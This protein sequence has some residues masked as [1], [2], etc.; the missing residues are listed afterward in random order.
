MQW[1]TQECMHLLIS[2]P[3]SGDGWVNQFISLPTHLSPPR[4]ENEVSWGRQ[5][6]V[7]ER[8]HDWDLGS[9]R[10]SPSSANGVNLVSRSLSLRI[11]VCKVRKEAQIACLWEWAWH[12]GFPK[13]LTWRSRLACSML[14][15]EELWEP[16]HGRKV[17]RERV[18]PSESLGQLHGDLQNW[19]ALW[20]SVSRGERAGC[21]HSPS[22]RVGCPRTGWHSAAWG[23]SSQWHS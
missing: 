7:R 18:K 4:K 22:T 11:L 10:F 3:R 16:C 8:R 20:H 15:K 9:R 12:V 5:W 1:I 13:H 17:Q 21:W 19:S 14:L 6:A 23:T 2:L